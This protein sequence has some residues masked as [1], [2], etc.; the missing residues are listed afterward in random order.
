[1][2]RLTLK[3]EHASAIHQHRQAVMIDGGDSG[4]GFAALYC[5]YAR[6]SGKAPTR[7]QEESLARLMS[8]I[9]CA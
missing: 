8:D 3:Y 2:D 9:L 6:L 7:E 5:A 1:M 4:A